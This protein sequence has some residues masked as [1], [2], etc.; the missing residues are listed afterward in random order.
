MEAETQKT[1][2][3]LEHQRRAVLFNQSE[4]QVQNLESRLRRSI[5]KSRPY[6][7]EKTICEQQLATQKDRINFLQM[8]VTKV[9]QAYAMS[10]KELERISEEIHTKRGDREVPCG[11]REPGVGAE[12]TSYVEE[13]RYTLRTLTKLSTSASL[14]LSEVDF[15]AELDKCDLQSLGS[16]SVATSSAAVSEDECIDDSELEELK[17]MASSTTTTPASS[18]T[19]VNVPCDDNDTSVVVRKRSSD[20]FDNVRRLSENWEKQMSDTISKLGVMLNIKPKDVTVCTED[21]EK[22]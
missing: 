10:L 2:S 16:V 20:T 11:V 3:G 21:K 7:E 4:Q 12:N 9:K 19:V 17:E 13:V 18:T 8:K 6:F 15:E 1:E 22:Y 5:N 14:N